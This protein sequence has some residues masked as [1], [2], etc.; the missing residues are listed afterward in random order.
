MQD[1]SH[2]L[3]KNNSTLKYFFFINESNAIFI[4]ACS[5]TDK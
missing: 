3:E 2:F 4:K 5:H 1:K